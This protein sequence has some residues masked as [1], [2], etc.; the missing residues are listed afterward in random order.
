MNGE[1]HE[2]VFRISGT[3]ADGQTW[4]TEGTVLGDFPACLNRAMHA[5]FEQLTGGKAVFGHPGLGCRGP[6]KISK[7]ELTTLE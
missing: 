2:I 7:F 3:A 6:Y 1:I 4:K 5:A